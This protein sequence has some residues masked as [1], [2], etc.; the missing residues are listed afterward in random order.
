VRHE[1]SS[2]VRG[3]G[4]A[5]ARPFSTLTFDPKLAG[6][7]GHSPFMR[8]SGAAADAL[9]APAVKSKAMFE[10]EPRK[11][12]AFPSGEPGAGGR[13]LPRRELSAAPT[14]GSRRSPN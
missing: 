11:Q 12:D 1:G 10:E 9:R 14:P 13:T 8:V 3:N 7:D 5:R 4:A 6:A 2:L